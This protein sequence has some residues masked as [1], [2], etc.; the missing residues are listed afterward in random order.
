MNS[1]NAGHGQVAM[2]DQENRS[3]FWSTLCTGLDEQKALVKERGFHKGL[4]LTEGHLGINSNNSF[5]I[6]WT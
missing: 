4:S 5:F 6:G 2:A 3:R 1:L